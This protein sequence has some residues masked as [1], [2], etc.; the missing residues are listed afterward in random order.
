MDLR[1][2]VSRLVD[3]RATH[4]AGRQ[5]LTV[6][7][8]YCPPSSR[9]VLSTTDWRRKLVYCTRRRVNV[10]RCEFFSSLMGKIPDGTALIFGDTRIF[11]RQSS[12]GRGKTRCQKWNGPVQTF[13][14]NI[15]V[16]QT[17]RNRF[18]ARNHVALKKNSP[19]SL[20]ETKMKQWNR[21]WAYVSRANIRINKRLYTSFQKSSLV[22]I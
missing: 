7:G 13:W 15:G 16:W 11:L 5:Q 21:I 3:H 18:I 4:W 12:R 17:H 8:R 9:Q 6:V 20:H 14:H 1:D 19:Y 10:Y 22:L 2:A